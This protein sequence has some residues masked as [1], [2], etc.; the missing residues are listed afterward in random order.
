[1]QLQ[2]GILP[3]TV[4]AT[5]WTLVVEDWAP[6]MIN[7]TGAASSDTVKTKLPA[8]HL[9][10]LVAWPNISSLVNASGIGTYTTQI[11]LHKESGLRVLFDAGS[12]TG[13]Y[14]VEING[15]AVEGVDQFLSKPIDITS[16]IVDG[17]NS[18]LRFFFISLFIS[19]LFIGIVITVATTLW[20]KLI[21]VWPA[22]YGS[23]SPQ[24]IGLT[25][26][27]T[28]TYVKDVEVI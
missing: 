18:K 12:V 5:S 6:A 2:P 1:M 14:G 28:F 27:V 15:V 10:E 3:A 25:G 23:Y 8:V 26:P 20:N 16:Y 17:T 22:L 24:Q 4:T 19:D 21:E 11:T 13:T 7:E 9:T